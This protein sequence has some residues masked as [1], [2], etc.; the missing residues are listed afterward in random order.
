VRI[1]PVSIVWRCPLD[2]SAYLALGQ[3]MEVGEQA[4]PGPECE[5]RRL[6]GWSGYWRWVRGPGTGR[7]WIR[8]HDR[9]LASGDR[10]GLEGTPTFY[11]NGIRHD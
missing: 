5:R 11:V 9:D 4:C 10:S 7:L 1:H 6:G 8:Q 3:Q 2:V